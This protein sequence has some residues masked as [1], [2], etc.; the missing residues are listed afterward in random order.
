MGVRARGDARGKHR[1]RHETL[2]GSVNPPLLIAFRKTK[3]RELSRV[4]PCAIMINKVELT[5]LAHESPGTS[6]CCTPREGVQERKDCLRLPSGHNDN[7]KGE[8][9]SIHAMINTTMKASY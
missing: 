3:S 1:S 4:Y 5:T 6:K 9:Q 8:E 7:R 2:Q